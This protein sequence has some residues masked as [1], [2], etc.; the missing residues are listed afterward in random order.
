MPVPDTFVIAPDFFQCPF[1]LKDYPDT[2]C[3]HVLFRINDTDKVGR[4][5]ICCKKCFNKANIDKRYDNTITNRV[6]N[7]KLGR[8]VRIK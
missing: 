3:K 6:F 2:E 5:Y 7:E 8:L 4:Y 1:C